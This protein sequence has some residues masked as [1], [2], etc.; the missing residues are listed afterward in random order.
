M[1]TDKTACILCS[2]NCGLEVEIDGD[3]FVKIRGDAQHPDS[4]GY[5]CQKAARLEHYQHHDDRLTQPL[6]R[7][8]DGS[9]E[10]ISWDQAIGEI[11]GKLVDVRKKHGPDTFALCGGGGQGNHLGAAYSQQL[12]A[13]MDSRFVYSSLAQEKTGDFWVNGRLFGRQ[14][15]HVTEGVEHADYVVFIGTNPF[16]AHGIPNA[17][18]TL[19][20]ISKD[21]NRTMVVV[22]PRRTETVRFADLHLQLRPGTDAFL[23]AAI[24]ATIVRNGWHDESFLREHCTG[25]EAVIEALRDVSPAAYAERAGVALEDIEQVAHGLSHARTAAVRVDLGTQHTLH[26]TLNAWLEK[27]LYLLTGH[28]GRE[29]TN[30]LHSW[31][32][33][34]VGHTDERRSIAGKRLRRT[35]H[36]EMM[37]IGGMYPPNILPDE[38][39][40]GGLR[41]IVVDSCNA[42]LSWPDT[43]ALEQA[44]AR[45][46]LLVVID[47]AMTET[48]RAADYVLPA[49]SQFEKWE[50]TGFNLEFPDN[51]FHLRHPLFPQTGDCLPEAEIYTRLLE[52]MGELPASFPVLRALARLEPAVTGH[53]AYLTALMARLKRDR[54]LRRYGASILYRT[55]DDRLPDDAAA[56]APLLPLAIDFV[57]RHPRQV[58]RAGIAGSGVRQGVNLFRAILAARS[59]LHISR[60]TY[61]ESWELIANEDGK[62]HLE[63]P[64]MLAELAALDAVSG[65]PEHPFIL[66]AGE[67]RSYNANQIFRDPKWRKIDPDGALRMHPDDAAGLGLAA[68][69]RAQCWNDRGAIDVTVELDD[70][71]RRGVVTL[72]H[73]YGMR[74][75]DGGPTGPQINRLTSKDRCD[76]LS[77][78]P[79]H[80]FVPVDI[81]KVRGAAAG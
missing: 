59:G 79:F 43:A 54:G 39:E 1:R 60:H 7:Q 67:R 31:M 3:R 26:T 29:G 77:R 74:H 21:P 22:D 69:D 30:T 46:D 5:I 14:N 62:I 70:G 23:I 55:L 15:C 63:I 13:A 64:E 45:L 4:K 10:A 72:P 27:L 11:A 36:H 33:P 20:E 16:Q 38:I 76:P 80:K 68:G 12:L 6:K 73:G 53:A 75:G 25:A 71:L 52:A 49:A 35:K 44:F 65:A 81:E 8:P 32:L 37:P 66:M 28:F 17:R 48:A 19:R 78:T 61:D 41:A 18:Q 51:Y 9:F 2:R 24:L 47:V 56:A 58:A 40:A 34:L 57:R 50:A 42:L